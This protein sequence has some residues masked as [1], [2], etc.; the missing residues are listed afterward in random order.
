MKLKLR[1]PL[2]SVLLIALLTACGSKTTEN[3]LQ[4]GYYTAQAAEFSH[5]W[6]E[7]VTI[8]VKGGSIVSVEY[9][10]E[11]ASGFIKSWDSNYMQTMLHSNG[12][13]PNEY[14]R[15]YAN[16]LL[17][18]QGEGSIDALSGASSSHGSF[19]LLAKA[20]LEQARLGDSS[21]VFV[22]TDAH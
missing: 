14:T 12:T 4:D 5:G 1:L 16:Q 17:E 22:D 15:Y 20:V 2:L 18:G 9:N 8:I 10:A 7:Y 3:E 19:Q 21:I 13:Y 6:K 11:N